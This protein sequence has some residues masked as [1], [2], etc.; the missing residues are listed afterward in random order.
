MMPSWQQ[1]GTANWKVSLALINAI[2][3]FPIYLLFFSSKRPECSL[4]EQSLSVFEQQRGRR[5]WLKMNILRRV[6]TFQ[7]LCYNG[8]EIAEIFLWNGQR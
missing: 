5:W 8:M 7:A 3:D 4:A 6:G 2:S 1:W